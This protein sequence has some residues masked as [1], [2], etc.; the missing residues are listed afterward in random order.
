MP[1]VHRYGAPHELRP[2]VRCQY[3][4]PS[5]LRPRLPQISLIS[6]RNGSLQLFDRDTSITLLLQEHTLPW[7]TS[8]CSSR[9]DGGLF[10][11]WVGSTSPLVAPSSRLQQLWLFQAIAHWWFWKFGSP[12]RPI[13]SHLSWFQCMKAKN[14]ALSAPRA[15]VWRSTRAEAVH[16]MPIAP[17]ELTAPASA[18][19]SL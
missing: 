18:P 15:L 7:Q 13:H 5:L 17:P 19:T 1:L 11:A 8:K 3:H 4:L 9:V 14:L 6:P 12:S 10:A 16:T 2:P